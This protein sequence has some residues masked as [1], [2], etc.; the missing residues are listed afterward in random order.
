MTKADRKFAHS[1]PM[2]LLVVLTLLMA[3]MAPAQAQEEPPGQDVLTVSIVKTADQLKEGS[4]ALV[5]RLQADPAPTDALL[6]RL[7]SE[8]TGS[9]LLPALLGEFNLTIPAGQSSLVF[10]LVTINDAIVE[11]NGSITLTVKTFGSGYQVGDDNSATVEVV[12]DDQP[13]TLE[14]LSSEEIQVAEYVGSVDVSVVATVGGGNRPGTYSA[15][16]NTYGGQPFI[17]WTLADTATSPDD[18][19][20]L[21]EV[22]LSLPGDYVRQ[23]S[24]DYVAVHTFTVTIVDDD[25][26]EDAEHFRLALGPSAGTGTLTIPSGPLR[27]AILANDGDDDPGSVSLSRTQPYVDWRVQATLND[28]NGVLD[29]TTWAW[30]RAESGGGPFTAIE[31]ATSRQ[32]TPTEDDLGW[33]LRATASYSDAHG[34]S[35]SAT[36][37]VANAVDSNPCV[38]D[39]PSNATTPLALWPGRSVTSHFCDLEDVDWISLWLTAGQAYRIEISPPHDEYTPRI[40][41]VFDSD[42]RLITGTHSYTG[43]PYA[44]RRPPG[45]IT[46]RATTSG[47]YYLEVKPSR[48]C[49]PP[50]LSPPERYDV[51]LTEAD[52]PADDVPNVEEVTLEFNRFGFKV[53][54]L[55]RSIETEGD[56]DTYLLHAEAGQRYVIKIRSHRGPHGLGGIYECI[57]RIASVFT[58]D[59]PL[60][61]SECAHRP[62]WNVTKFLIP[63]ADESFLITVGSGEGTGGYTL[64]IKDETSPPPTVYDTPLPE[65]DLAA[66]TS[67]TAEVYINDSWINGTSVLGQIDLAYDKDWYRVELEAG[68]RYQI[69]IINEPNSADYGIPVTLH[70]PHMRLH[71]A[72]GQ[73]IEGT[74]DDDSGPSLSAQLNYT[75]T[76][77]GTYYIEVAASGRQIGTYGVSVI[78]S[79]DTETIHRPLA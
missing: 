69:D 6:V 37:T 23:E 64:S 51:T 75:P 2:A 33:F 1:K 12:D 17:A 66:D 53:A 26:E 14:F 7:E 3:W 57:H 47:A 45:A 10:G 63:D 9:F 65:S 11:A 40:A 71:D 8:Q 31:G 62:G 55:E 30:S 29:G 52:G 18:F 44:T 13:V 39:A 19:T 5:F 54:N 70:D 72:D 76:R 16:G 61:Y 21:S 28:P 73:R 43:N 79:S 56:R 42:S 36:S 20:S 50:K 34:P 25:S 49:I 35:K 27:I 77:T 38:S 22:L 32:Y 60:G 74:Y 48:C 58:P 24:G 41:G 59:E 4:N 68:Q 46:F 78:D 15:E 67:T